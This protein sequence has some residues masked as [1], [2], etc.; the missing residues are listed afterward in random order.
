MKSAAPWRSSEIQMIDNPPRDVVYAC[1]D[2]TLDQNITMSDLD[3]W[4]P[5][6]DS[7]SSCDTGLYANLTEADERPHWVAHCDANADY[8]GIDVND[9]KV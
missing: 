4:N 1:E 5:W 7:E 8:H 3:G 2:I 6:V 9:F